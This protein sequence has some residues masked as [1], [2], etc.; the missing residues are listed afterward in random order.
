MNYNNQEIVVA[1]Y[2]E[3]LEWINREPFNRHPIII[4]N[5][6]DNENFVK[7]LNIKKIIQLPNVGREMHTYF[8]HIIENYDNLADVT[9]FLPGSVDLEHKYDRSKRVVETV[10]TTNN[11]VFSGWREDVDY[12]FQIDNWLS[13]HSKNK[14]LN[15]DAIMEPSNIRPYGE[16]FKN[17]FKNG[18][19]NMIV[20]LNSIISVW[21]ENILQKPKSYYENL[22]NMVN[23][24]QNPEVVHYLERSWCAV[25]YPYNDNAILV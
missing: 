24:H 2:N 17:T 12:N 13:T 6:S 18:E 4:Y 14:D 15:P 21:R 3:D 25:F 7:N 9:I 8:Y 19:Q 5:K 1:R 23:K 16:W 22:I 11:T 10:E 20:S